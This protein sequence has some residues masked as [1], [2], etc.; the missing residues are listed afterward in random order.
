MVGSVFSHVR[1]GRPNNPRGLSAPS[2]RFNNSAVRLDQDDSQTF[3]VFFLVPM[4]NLKL[5]N[6]FMLKAIYIYIHVQ[7]TLLYQFS[8][9]STSMQGSHIVILLVINF[10][11][12]CIYLLK[13]YHNF[14]F[15]LYEQ[16][17]PKKLQKKRRIKRYEKFY[18]NN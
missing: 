3:S 11:Q 13:F 9:L 8:S 4:H 5:D 15:L 6:S 18:N 12:I 14:L 17:K 16:Y 2:G 7:C 10:P 1:Q